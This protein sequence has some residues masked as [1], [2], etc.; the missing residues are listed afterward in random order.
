MTATQGFATFLLLTV[1]CLILVVLSGL[2]HKRKQHFA[3]VACAVALLGV[4][5]Y[6]AEQ[7]GDEYDLET[8]GA[9]TPIHLALAK[10]TVLAYLLPLVSGV[11]TMRDIRRKRV[12]FKLAMFVLFMTGVT[13]ATGLMMILS[14]EP[15]AM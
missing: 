3:L 1:V 6:F 11:M 13:F 5:I 9:I 2:K 10:I 8:A 14:A 7:L 4:T 15:L 12:H